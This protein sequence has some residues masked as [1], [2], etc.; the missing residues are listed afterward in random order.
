MCSSHAKYDAVPG[1]SAAPGWTVVDV[2]ANVGAYS[3]WQ[4]RNMESDGTIVA[5]EASP[6]TCAVLASNITSNHADEQIS[7][8]QRAVWCE[9]GPID[10]L[11]SARSSST[12]GV[13]ETLD[14][15]L[16]EDAQHQVVEAITLADLLDRSELQGRVV[17][18]L[19]LDIEG[20][21][22]VA[23]RAAEPST[24]SRIRRLVVEADERTWSEVRA[25]LEQGGFDFVA[26]HRRVGYFAAALR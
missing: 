23:L 16:I 9:S 24:L 15:S 22:A 1:F 19:K 20:A 21:E 25:V 4:W 17:D 18:V 13:A 8:V 3:L 7:V 5:V 26:R 11:S 14:R 10:F 2:G 6:N 12:S